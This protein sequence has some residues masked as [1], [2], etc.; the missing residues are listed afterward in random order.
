[1]RQRRAFVVYCVE[2]YRY[3]K[4]LTGAQVALLFEQ[5]GIFDYLE[6]NYESL[7]TTGEQ[8]ITQ[9]IDE[10]IALSKQ[11]AGDADSQNQL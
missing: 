4:H 9:D 2:R 8:Y 6:Q 7:H 11:N 1:M 10:M 3:L 5:H